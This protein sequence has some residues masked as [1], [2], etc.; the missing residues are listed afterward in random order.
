[1]PVTIVVLND[2]ETYTDA[3]GCSIVVIKNE[4]ADLLARGQVNV[5][6]ITPIAEI[7]IDSIAN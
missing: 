4:D 2:G 1:M 3:K 6:D 5:K 7:G